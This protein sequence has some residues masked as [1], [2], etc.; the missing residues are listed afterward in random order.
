MERAS[1]D[2]LSNRSI[3]P[4]SRMYCSYPVPN[5]NFCNNSD[6]C[7]V[8]AY[9]FM[10]SITRINSFAPE[11]LKTG[12]S[13]RGNQSHPSRLCPSESQTQHIPNPPVG[14]LHIKFRG[15]NRSAR[16]L[17]NSVNQFKKRIKK[18][19]NAPSG[20]K[21]SSPFAGPDVTLAGGQ[22]GNADGV[23]FLSRNR[24]SRCHD[25][26][27]LFQSAFAFSIIFRISGLFFGE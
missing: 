10:L 3:S 15:Q 22:L 9:S 12:L 6:T 20:A 27:L 11:P 8:S 21:A 14:G 26:R 16:C 4:L 1:S 17:S 7:A 2:T 25:V 5:N 18:R 13:I 23:A 19:I 24:G